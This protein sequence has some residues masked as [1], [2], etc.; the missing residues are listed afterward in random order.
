MSKD[1]LYDIELQCIQKS[2]S[3]PEWLFSYRNER[4]GELIFNNC[5]VP[6]ENVLGKVN[7]GAKVLMSGLDYERV[8]LAGGPLGVMQNCWDI[9]VP[10]V[11]ERKQFDQPIGNFQLIQGKLADIYTSMNASKLLFWTPEEIY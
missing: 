6:E 10:Y 4:E 8:V 1:E 2:A 5:E 11:H 3:A 7:S 9:I